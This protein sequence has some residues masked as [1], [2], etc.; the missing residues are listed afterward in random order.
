MPRVRVAPY[1][2]IRNGPSTVSQV[3]GWYASGV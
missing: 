2:D 1:F 3:N